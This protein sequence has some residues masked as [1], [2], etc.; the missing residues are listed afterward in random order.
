M[1][2]DS[3]PMCYDSMFV[4]LGERFSYNIEMGPFESG[5][6]KYPH[7]AIFLQRFF[8]L[9]IS[10][11]SEHNDFIINNASTMASSALGNVIPF[12]G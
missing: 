12:A 10:I 5:R 6:I 8:L 11:A 9:G 1:D 4:S 2:N 3:L 7:S